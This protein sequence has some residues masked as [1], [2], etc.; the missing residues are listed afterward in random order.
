VPA[1]GAAPESFRAE[2]ITR[3]LAEAVRREAADAPLKLMEVC[4][5]HTMSI[6]R[7]GLRQLL[8]DGLKLLSGPGC[9]V[10]VTPTRYVDWAVAAAR[11]PGVVV[12]TFGDM[13]RVPGSTSSLERERAAGADVRIVYSPL[14]ALA[15]AERL[16]G[17][18]VV[19][20]GIGF[21]TTAPTVAATIAEAHKRETENFVVLCGHKLVPPALMHLAS[22]GPD[23][24]GL[25]CPGHVSVVIGWGAYVPV[26]E[27][28]GI[29]CVVAGFE[30]ADI[31][32]G[33][34]MLVRQRN[35]GRAAVENAYPRVVS[36]EGNLHA[37]DLMR[38]VFREADSDWRG[39]G[40]IPVSGLALRGPYKQFDA[41]ARI[42]VDVEPTRETPGCLCGGILAGLAG[43]LD[44]PHFGKACTPETPLGPCM[45]SSE[46]TCAAHYR[47]GRRNV[48]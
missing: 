3:G 24:G 30:P 8:P 38:E 12:A 44:C 34:L 19:F 4:G 9:P 43:P 37:L 25:L 2:P 35:S 5:T 42:D 36:E 15:L 26:A 27:R 47:Y 33:V 16:S 11:R 20:L 23:L 10:C 14:D 21:E 40:C 39:L 17:S 31:L 7:F 1:D 48:E 6:Y 28:F 22:S 32:R 29:P 45:V 18:T 13:V 41:E 46:G